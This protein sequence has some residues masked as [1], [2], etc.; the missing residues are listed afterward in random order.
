M[1]KSIKKVMIVED[2][3]LISTYLKMCLETNG[4]QVSGIEANGNNV[5]S[6]YEGSK[7][8]AILMD[9]NLKGEMSGIDAFYEL[10]RQDLNPV[11]IFITGFSDKKILQAAEKTGPRAIFEKPVNMDDLIRTLRL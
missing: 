7:P 10:K 8:D 1:T 11:V 3:C 2:E 4:F 9:I 6:S 5:L